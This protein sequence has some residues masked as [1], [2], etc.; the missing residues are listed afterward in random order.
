M[1]LALSGPVVRL[2][3]PKWTRL[4][5]RNQSLGC[6][7]LQQGY[8]G[9]LGTCRYLPDLGSCARVGSCF[10]MPVM[11]M[12]LSQGVYEVPSHYPSAESL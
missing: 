2:I 3:S 8:L 12:K 1:I 10:L 6:W 9:S 7:L 11:V 4:R 5:A